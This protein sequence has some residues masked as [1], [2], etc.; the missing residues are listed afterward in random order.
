MVA[1][2]PAVSLD[3][4]SRLLLLDDQVLGGFARAFFFP[5][6]KP[7]LLGASAHVVVLV[8]QSL[9]MVGYLSLESVAGGLVQPGSNLAV[10]LV[11]IDF[12]KVLALQGPLD[13]HVDDVDPRGFQIFVEG[14][15]LD[16]KGVDVLHIQLELCHRVDGED[17]V[18][19]GLHALDVL[20]DNVAMPVLLLLE[21][22]S[23]RLE[24]LLD[25]FVL[26][27]VL[28]VALDPVQSGVLENTGYGVLHVVNDEKLAGISFTLLTFKKH[29]QIAADALAELLDAYE[30][31]VQSQ[32]RAL[33]HDV[34][35][36]AGCQ[37]CQGGGKDTARALEA[38]V[39]VEIGKALQRLVNGLFVDLKV[40]LLELE[41]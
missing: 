1:R 32:I 37:R 12:E 13:A 19:V 23:L 7:T 17:F 24:L 22:K 3:R 40:V 2:E 11:F 33:L 16:A 20:R 28:Q 29:A 27:D 31:H 9:Q 26:Q 5:A 21:L 15:V 38:K 4:F 10:V 14:G 41:F 25:M 39:D 35:G 30:F 8:T 6:E 36:V 18:L 34:V